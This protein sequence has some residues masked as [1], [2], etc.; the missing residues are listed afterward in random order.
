MNKP[1]S[2][3]THVANHERVA[4]GIALACCLFSFVLGLIILRYPGVEYDE[5]LFAD[6]IFPPYDLEATISIFHHNIATMLMPYL[7][8]VKSFLYRAWFHVW[9]PSAVSIRLPALVIGIVSVWL[10]FLL[11]R[12]TAGRTAAV[13]TTVLLATDVS[14]LLTNCF[15]W[16]PVALQ[17]LFLISG[18]LLLVH[19]HQEGRGWALYA[20]FFLFGLGMWDK[21]LFVWMLGGLAVAA[22][23][24]FPRELF[25]AVTLRRVALSALC[26]VVGALP[27]VIY[28]LRHYGQTARETISIS[29]AG[30]DQKTLQFWM[31]VNGSVMLRMAGEAGQPQEPQTAVERLATSVQTL[32]G[33][34]VNNFNDYGLVAALALLPLVWRTPARRPLLFSL[35]FMAVVWAQMAFTANAG[36]SV[37]HVVLMWPFPLFFIAVA[38]SESFKRLGRLGKP[39]LALV[40]GLMAA[41]N[42]LIY[43]TCL[44]RF[45]RHGAVRVWTDAIYPLADRLNQ[46]QSDEIDVV[47]WGILN[48]VRVLDRGRLQLVELGFILNQPE[49]GDRE[50][51]YLSDLISLPHHLFV[52]HMRGQES[53]VG[54]GDRLTKFALERGYQRVLLETIADRNQR[55]VFQIYRFQSDA[56]AP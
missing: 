27:L 23:L 56:K 10:F 5:A 53:F 22:A 12:R 50:K 52:N 55:P 13:V 29:A 2:K 38:F 6:S 26:F 36:T 45:I 43:N 41:Q 1:I 44:N 16:G 19:F 7:G 54:V 24:V 46:H 3:A 48:S 18:V 15:D 11:A 28:N 51:K 9:R 42:L 20:G 21:A 17:H 33:D 34:Q 49:F 39:L 4:T 8:T 32:A 25:R 37:H 35:I 47:D 31:T 40:V 30:F 14:F